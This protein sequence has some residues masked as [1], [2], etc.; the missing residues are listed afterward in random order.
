MNYNAI[1]MVTPPKIDILKISY[2]YMLKNLGEGLN[3]IIM[4][5]NTSTRQSIIDAFGNDPRVSFLDEETI[6]D[7]LTLKRI[8]EIMVELCGKPHRAG[9]YY[10]QFLKMAYS[11][12]CEDDYYLVFDSDTIPLNPI[13]YFAEDDRPCFITKIEYHKPYF[14]TIDVLFDGKVGR[15]DP[16]ESYIAENMMISKALMQ[17]MI[18]K[19]NS[20]SNLTGDTFY[21]KILRAVDSKIVRATGFSEFE[22]YGNYVMTLHPESYH[23]IKLRTQR[24]GA[25]IV[26]DTP[27]TEQLEWAAKDYDIMS[28]EPFGRRWLANKTKKASIREKYTAKEIF[29]K[30]IKLSDM[31]DRLKRKKVIYYDEEY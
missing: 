19:I 8:Q 17:E 22:T 30:Y 18:E 15:V 10:Q 2:P 31:L 1:I 3:K 11:Y 23:K 24:L 25:F 16:K 7:G 14:D 21:E 6:M 13:P 20:N 12:I 28:I 5:A 4:V 27:T 26:G 29:L 9:W